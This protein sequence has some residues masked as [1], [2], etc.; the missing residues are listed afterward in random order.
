[1]T[2]FNAILDRHGIDHDDMFK[3]WVTW[4]M[5]SDNLSVWWKGDGRYAFIDK[6]SMDLIARDDETIM[7]YDH[8]GKTTP[9]GH[10]CYSVIGYYPEPDTFL[11]KRIQ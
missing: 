11:V 10:I 1:M 8:I 6:S 4:H 3:L 7:D 9:E 5:H 2:D